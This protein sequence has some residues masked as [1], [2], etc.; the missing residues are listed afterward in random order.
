MVR[1]PPSSSKPVTAIIILAES[2]ACRCIVEEEAF[3]SKVVEVV[4]LALVELVAA[5]VEEEE[6]E[7]LCFLFWAADVV[8]CDDEVVG[9]AGVASVDLRFLLE[10][11]NA[12]T[13]AVGFFFFVG[14]LA[15]SAALV[16]KVDEEEEGLV[17]VEGCFGT[18]GS[19][20]AE[21]LLRPCLVLLHCSRSV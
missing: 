21:V 19:L 8:A 18:M 7:A 9:L 15:T 4:F 20:V 5:G 10:L 14:S 6:V 13:V 2:A 17:L 11:S 12:A 16:A 3:L 1:S